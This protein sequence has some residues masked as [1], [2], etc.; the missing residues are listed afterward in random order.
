MIVPATLLENWSRELARFAPS[1]RVYRHSGG[2]RTRRPS[3]LIKPDVVLVTY[4]TAVDRSGRSRIRWGWDLV[5]LDEAQSIKNPDTQ[6]SLTA[7]AIPRHAAFAVTGT[8]LE[9]R[10]LDTWS[11]ADFAVPGYLGTRSSFQAT[12][13]SE[14]EL[15]GRALRPLILRREVKSVAKDLPEKV[16]A[17]VALEMFGPEAQLYEEVREAVRGERTHVPILALLTKLRMFTAHPDCVYGRAPHPVARSAKL[18]RLLEILEELQP[19]RVKSLVFVAFNEAADI[20]VS[21]VQ[22]RFACPVWTVDGRTAV[23]ERQRI[24]DQYSVMRGPA[25]LVLNPAVCRSWPQHS[26]G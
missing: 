25:V 11:L 18:T 24:I 23:A 17:D 4:E 3:E 5:V 9:N 10:T 8:P 13:E 2:S 7:R 20:I 21:A 19:R 1:L 15:L 14:P 16:E 6:R 22:G 26:S 12:I